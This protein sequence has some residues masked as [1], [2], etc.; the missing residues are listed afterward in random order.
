MIYILI[1]K[2]ENGMFLFTGYL[3]RLYSGLTVE[4]CKRKY[5]REAYKT[6]L[7]PRYKLVFIRNY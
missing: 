7:N 6:G 5:K 3:R 4:Q 2:R 1:D